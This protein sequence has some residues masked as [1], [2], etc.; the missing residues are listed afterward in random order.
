MGQTPY[1]VQTT[2]QMPKSGGK[3]LLNGSF[4]EP[5]SG[6]GKELKW[7]WLNSQKQVRKRAAVLPPPVFHPEFWMGLEPIPLGVWFD[8]TQT[9]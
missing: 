4:L 7:V 9:P 6:Y 1:G 5:L 3:L 2:E 8:P